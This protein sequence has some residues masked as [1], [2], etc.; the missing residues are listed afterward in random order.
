M[1]GEVFFAVLPFW[2]AYNI[3]PPKKTAKARAYD[4]LVCVLESLDNASKVRVTSNS[5][6]NAHLHNSQS[7]PERQKR[8]RRAA[9]VALAQLSSPRPACA[10]GGKAF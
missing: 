1:G 7:F 5:P 2:E 3:H 9:A 6:P 8:S 4:C 10:A